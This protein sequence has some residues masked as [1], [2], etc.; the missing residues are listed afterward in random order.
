[1]MPELLDSGS[2]LSEDET[3]LRNTQSTVDK[4]IAKSRR[5]TQGS[6]IEVN[7][8]YKEAASEEEG[9]KPKIKLINQKDD[10]FDSYANPFAQKSYTQEF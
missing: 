7:E 5:D 1:M 4:W 9:S 6:Q 3:N 8:V 10:G 2:E